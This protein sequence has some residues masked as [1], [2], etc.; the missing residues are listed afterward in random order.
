MKNHA[1][2]LVIFGITGDL[3]RRMTF[4]ALYRSVE[5]TWRIVPP[6]LDHPSDVRPYPRGSWGPDEAETLLRGHPRWQQ[7]WLP[8]RD[9][10]VNRTSQR[11]GDGVD[12]RI[13]LIG[14][15]RLAH[16]LAGLQS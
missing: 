8:R 6:L 7:L 12:L 15:G 3:A 4:R 1:D 16:A 11:A 14:V 10:S 13:R 9:E 2:R 5:E